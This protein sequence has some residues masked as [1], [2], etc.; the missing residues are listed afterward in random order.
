MQS[1]TQKNAKLNK[2]SNQ[3]PSL[4]FPFPCFPSS[5]QPPLPP[6]LHTNNLTT[7]PR[8][9]RNP[10]ISILLI[11][12]RNRTAL[13][14]RHITNRQTPTGRSHTRTFIHS[15]LQR[16]AFPAKHVVAVLR[17]PCVVAGREVEGLRAVGGPFGFVV[18]CCGVPDDLERG[19]VLVGNEGRGGGER[20]SSMSCGI[21][22]GCEDGQAPPVEEPVKDCGP[23][24]GYAT[25]SWWLGESR[26]TPSQH[27]NSH[28]SPLQYSNSLGKEDLRRE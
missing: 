21:L 18:E 14:G 11:Q 15:S 13:G 20:A 16:V 23:V 12:L 1:R 26:L 22:T 10:P 5:P 3:T 17:I 19:N 24:V 27:L 28:Q 6:H 7:N 4:P 25:W 2:N 9:R 8:Q